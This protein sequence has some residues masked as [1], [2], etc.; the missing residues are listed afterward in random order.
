MVRLFLVKIF[1]SIL[2]PTVALAGAVAIGGG[3]DGPE[4]IKNDDPKYFIDSEPPLACD[5]VTEA[6]VDT[7]KDLYKGLRSRLLKLESLVLTGHPEKM[8]IE[9]WLASYHSLLEETESKIDRYNKCLFQNQLRES[10]EKNLKSSENKNFLSQLQS[11]GTCFD[12]SSTDNSALKKLYAPV[13]ESIY[14]FFTNKKSLTSE[15]C[16]VLRRTYELWSGFNEGENELQSQAAAEIPFYNVNPHNSA[17][18]HWLRERER[19]NIPPE[20]LP[21]MHVDTHT[22]LGHVHA[23]GAGWSRKL[24]LNQLANLMIIDDDEKF[25]NHIR[26]QLSSQEDVVPAELDAVLSQEALQLR[27]QI[28]SH[29]RERVHHIA[30]PVVG[31]LATDVANSLVM[32]L[33]PWSP[34]LPR[35]EYKNGKV[36]PYKVKLYKET[37]EDGESDYKLGTDE[38]KIL[39][40]ADSPIQNLPKN[41][42]VI[43]EF[44]L[45][46]M[47]ANLEERIGVTDSEGK[48]TSSIITT[49]EM[50]EKFNYANYMPKGQ[51]KFI[52]DIDLDAFVS[53]GKS[54]DRVVPLS[55]GRHQKSYGNHNGHEFSNET[56]PEVEVTLSEFNLIEGRLDF[57]F[58]Q[59][60]DMKEKGYEPAVITIADSTILQSIAG[61]ADD[62]KSGGNFTPSCLVFLLNYRMREELKAIYPI[63]IK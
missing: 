43:K 8:T 35:S 3:K 47:D 46:V 51:K 24:D 26:E 57:F 50:E 52:L 25:K 13:F 49:R 58:D 7:A 39:K 5:K 17:F 33:P 37:Y 41:G 19:G 23:D 42:K 55:F 30:Q 10:I 38:S 14:N 62:S 32:A 18:P 53:E 34:R 20:G 63:D 40:T 16:E 59:L 21:L 54:G 31:G 2:L 36:D 56:D 1:I 60:R 22:D 61:N 48:E 45:T 12:S 28:Y 29:M 6:E 27:M 11:I 44:D 15:D 4:N 9:Q